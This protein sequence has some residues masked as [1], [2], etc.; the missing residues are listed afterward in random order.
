M[1]GK[2]AWLL[3]PLLLPSLVVGQDVDGLTA[4][5]TATSGPNWFNNSGWLG[6]G[7]PCSWHGVTC[8]S[9]SQWQLDLPGMRGLEG[10]LPTQVG[11]LG[12]MARLN[13]EGTS[14]SGTLPF[15]IL[16]GQ[17]VFRL[18][19]L[20]L[21]RTSLSGTISPTHLQWSE[22]W[23]LHLETTFLSGTL[24]DELHLGQLG[25]FNIGHTLLSG[26]LP[27]NMDNA[28]L[29]SLHFN[30]AALSGTLPGG[31]GYF[32]RLDFSSTSLSGSVPNGLSSLRFFQSKCLLALGVDP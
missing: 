11:R 26:T 30:D 24:P 18:L 5:Y 12:G 22:I 21:A 10:T 23:D 25:H 2:S 3:H 17:Q 1:R 14:L 29:E 8:I 7:S 20:D 27:P 13:L 4:L 15:A 9:G 28:L 19:E 32:T 6:T 16:D 31:M